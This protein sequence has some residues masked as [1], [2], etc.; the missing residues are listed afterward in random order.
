[1]EDKD[2]AAAAELYKTLIHTALQKNVIAAALDGYLKAV[3]ESG[4]VAAMDAAADEVLASTHAT[5]DAMRTAHFFKGK[6]LQAGGDADGALAHYRKAAEA[7]SR[8]AAE[9]RYQIA[10]IL[11][12]QQA[13]CGRKGSVRFLRSQS[14]LSI[15][16]GQG[17]PDSGRHLR[18]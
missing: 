14:A 5:D 11:F 16:D 10:A 4:D 12:A 2:Y 13:G 7:R 8:D 18:R 6:S 3:G 17:F 1:M 9:A 15:L